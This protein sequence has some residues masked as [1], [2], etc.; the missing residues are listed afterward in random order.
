VPPS[1]LDS[2][3]FKR[4]SNT[5]LFACDILTYIE[6]SYQY[7]RRY[8]L[9]EI[10]KIKPSRRFQIWEEVEKEIDSLKESIKKEGLMQAICVTPIE[11]SNSG[12]QPENEKHEIIYGHRKYYAA[13]SA[14]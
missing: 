11:N 3:G 1:S 4:Y 7:E 6:T 5:R 14:G 10:D 12:F 9:I 2:S 13:K 8:K